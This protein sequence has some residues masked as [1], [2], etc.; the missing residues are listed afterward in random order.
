MPSVFE[1]GVVRKLFRVMW[2][3]VTGGWRKLHNEQLNG[4]YC[5]PNVVRGIKWRRMEWAGHVERMGKR[6][7][8]RFL[9][10]KPEGKSPF[11]RRRHRWQHNIKMDL[12]EVGC[13]CM[14]RIELA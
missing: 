10:G 7:V 6:G 12:Q 8:Y 2:D 14:D 4:L 3:V 1:N 13:G 5:A 11:G 9:V